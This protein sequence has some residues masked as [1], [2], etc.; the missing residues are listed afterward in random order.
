MGI[1]IGQPIYGYTKELGKPTRWVIDSQAATNV[2]SIYQLSFRGYGTA[3]I[4]AELEKATTYT[5]SSYRCLNSGNGKPVEKHPY[6]WSSSTVAKIL[7]SQEYMQSKLANTKTRKRAI[8]QTLFSGFLRCGDCGSNLYYHFNQDNP[9][10]KYYNCSNYVGNRGDCEDTHYIRLDVLEERVLLDINQQIALA[11][12]SIF[13]ENVAKQKASDS[14]HEAQALADLIKATA[15]RQKELSE[16]LT[17]AQEDKVKGGIDDNV[18][19]ILANKF[20]QEREQLQR[21]SQ[22]FHD[23]LETIRNY[24]SGLEY[25]KEVQEGCGNRKKICV[26]F[27]NAVQNRNRF[28]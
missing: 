26:N 5:P 14:R 28:V 15:A 20:R 1:P 18:F 7:R 23:Q 11:K 13:W 3:Q 24:Q 19:T 4:A 9:T 27:K 17:T 16:L 12:D 10:I 22:Q 2:R 8:A 25:M 21:Q 6:R